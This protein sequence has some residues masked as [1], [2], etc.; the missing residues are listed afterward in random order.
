MI[1]LNGVPVMFETFPNGESKLIYQSILE[2]VIDGENSLYFKYSED[3]DLI[4]LMFVKEYLDSFEV[5]VSL[6]VGYMPYSRMD[7]TEDHS[8]FTLKYIANFINKLNFSKV[9]IIEPHSDVT[10]AVIDNSFSYYI[11]FDLL[12]LVENEIGFDKEKDYL[13]FPD[14]GAQKRYHSLKGYKQLVGYKHRD[15]NTGEIKSLDVV[16]EYPSNASDSNIIIVDD[17]SSFGGTFLHSGNKLKELGFKNI[18]LLVAHCENS[19]FKGK[20]LQHGSPIKKIFTTNSIITSTQNGW[21][22]DY[23]DKLHIYNLEEIL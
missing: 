8:P 17:L 16:G 1:L 7:R 13:F 3:G 11:N 6:V 20:L 22:D 5:Y 18:Y 21:D 4:K 12:K 15:F 10:P 23:S 14:A 19:I 2:S 9:C